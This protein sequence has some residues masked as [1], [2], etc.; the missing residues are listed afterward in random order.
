V[1]YLIRKNADGSVSCI[2]G[3]MDLPS[4]THWNVTI[5]VPKDKAYFET[6]SLFYNPTPLDQAY[7]VWMNAA[8]KAGDDLEFI[9]PGTAFIGHDYAAPERPWPMT[10]D[11]RDLSFFKNHNYEG[12]PGSLFIFGKLEDFAGGY[13]HNSQFGFGHWALYEDM[14]GHKFFHWSLAPS[15]DIWRKLLTDTDGQYFEPQMGRL[16]DQEDH[17]FLTPYSADHWRE[18]WFPY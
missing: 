10:D 8:N 17:E 15:G 11:G 3:I 5:T 14:P 16:F 13:W 12:A 9:F 7:Y 1:D 18:V 6:R 2:V 4:R